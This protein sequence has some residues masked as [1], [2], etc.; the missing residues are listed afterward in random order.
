MC[1][2][3]S[4]L[5]G[6]RNFIQCIRSNKFHRTSSRRQFILILA[7][8]AFV[9]IAPLHFQHHSAFPALRNIH[10]ALLYRA[11]CGGE[12]SEKYEDALVTNKLLKDIIG[13]VENQ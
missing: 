2:G 9:Y 6:A 12:N 13:C 7:T 8:S 1:I 4:L 10:Q 5:Y 3:C 11:I